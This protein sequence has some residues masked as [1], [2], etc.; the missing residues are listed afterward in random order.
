[1]SICT[2][3]N[4]SGLASLMRALPT[5]P[6]PLLHNLE[7]CQLYSLVFPPLRVGSCIARPYFSSLCFEVYLHRIYNLA[8]FMEDQTSI[9]DL[10]IP[11]REDATDPPREPQKGA[12]LSRNDQKWETLKQEIWT[13]YMMEKHT[14]PQTMLKIEQAHNFKAS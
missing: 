1:V 6:Q 13:V 11:G 5:Q 8:G 4:Q 12:V 9:M 2:F 7:G 14:L 10:D 3:V